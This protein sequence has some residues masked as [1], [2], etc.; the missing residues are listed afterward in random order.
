MNH[1]RA[2][3]RP[4]CRAREERGRERSR[5]SNVKPVLSVRRE[6]D[7]RPHV[8]AES[9][10]SGEG[11][12]PRTRHTSV[13]PRTRSSTANLIS[14]KGCGPARAV[15][16][17][18]ATVSG[19]FP[20]TPQPH[21]PRISRRCPRAAATSSTRAA[22]RC[23]RRGQF[24]ERFALTLAHGPRVGRGRGQERHAVG[25][26]QEVAPVVAEHRHAGGVDHS[27]RCSGDRPARDGTRDEP[28]GGGQA[29]IERR[30]AGDVLLLRPSAPLRK[31]PP[32]FLAEAKTRQARSP[33][34][35]A[36]RLERGLVGHLDHRRGVAVP[37]R[38]VLVAAGGGG[39]RAGSTVTSTPAVGRAPYPPFS[40]MSMV[41]RAT[42]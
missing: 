16:K 38:K 14:S 35:S 17:A 9:R 1:R 41:S 18:R 25:L 37:G 19:A 20:N 31:P 29:G 21:A 2:R 5:G 42:A 12:D 40:T 26:L 39:S 4:P 10:R 36:G 23:S 28:A 8:H 32:A 24:A 11:R 22:R 6:T 34:I 7:L 27:G 15:A 33:P 13:A 30:R 3:P